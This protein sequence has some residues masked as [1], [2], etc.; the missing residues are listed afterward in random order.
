MD[1]V[2]EGARSTMVVTEL[3]ATKDRRHFMVRDIGNSR[4]GFVTKAPSMN[5]LTGARENT[6]HCW[7]C[8]GDYCEHVEVVGRVHVR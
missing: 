8:N 4:V 1:T 2:T 7:V 5:F 6:L 3:P